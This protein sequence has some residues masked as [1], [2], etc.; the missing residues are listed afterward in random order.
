MAPIGFISDHLE[1]LYDIDIELKQRAA[2]QGMQLER[3]AMLN[4][5]PP[6]IEILASVIEQHET[7]LV[8]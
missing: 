4:A 7:S 6:L 5:T 3:I 8:R 1:V 2:G